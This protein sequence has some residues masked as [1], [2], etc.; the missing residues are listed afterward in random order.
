MGFAVGVVFVE[1]IDRA[2]A[3]EEFGQGCAGGGVFDDRDDLH[4]QELRPEGAVLVDRLGGVGFVEG[5]PAGCVCLVPA[6]EDGDAGC[7]GCFAGEEV[8]DGF[9]TDFWAKGPR[10]DEFNGFSIGCRMVLLGA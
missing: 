3:L 4:I 2:L 6:T 5:E 7:W 1:W 9:F 10:A 8:V